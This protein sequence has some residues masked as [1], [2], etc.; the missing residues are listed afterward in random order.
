MAGKTYRTGLTLAQV[1]DMFPSDA[2]AERW[3]ADV[4]WPDGLGC[5][6]CGS[7]S[8]QDGCKHK[9]M[10][11]RCRDCAKK[12]SV[13]TG[14][15]MAESKIGY[16]TWAIAIYLLNTSL[17][18]V[19]STK[20]ARDLGISQK[21][22]WYLAH[23]IRET[24]DDSGA[25]FAGPVEVDE[26]FIGGK[27]ANMHERTRD[28]MRRSDF[29]KAPVVGVKDRESGQVRARAVADTSG[30]TLRGFVRDSARPGSQVY[31][32]G[33][34]AYTPLEGEYR[35][36]AVQHSAGTYVIE[37]AHTNGIE[38]FWSM[39]KRGYVGTY[40]QMSP[41]H[42]DRYVREFVGR[43]NVREMDTL[44]Q[45]RA[46]ARGLVGKRLRYADLVA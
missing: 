37:Q 28:R 32:D 39:L 15:V 26:T 12:F 24:W 17:K 13:R 16:R 35:H 3:F 2:A 29:D 45:M 21:S 20:L 14:T 38:S 43:H 27:A 46:I 36:N 41:K 44:D 4:R 34:A 31:S 8:V 7:V 40:H 6:H 30:P 33:H 23:R 19:A 10:P 1:F 5:P 11:Y 9:T 42:L 18:G 22:A 25:P